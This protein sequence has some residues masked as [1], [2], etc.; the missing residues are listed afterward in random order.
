MAKPHFNPLV[1]EL[2]ATTPFVGPETLERQRGRRFRARLGA[3]ESAFGPSP[4]AIAAMQQAV[5][6]TW[7]YGDPESHDLKAEIAA[8]HGVA[9]KNVAIGAGIDGLLG[10]STRLFMQPGDT[11]V[12]SDGAYPTFNYFAAGQG[13]RL[14]KIPYT[15]DKEDLQALLD[16]AIRHGAR[17]I[18]VSNPDNPMG[19]WWSGTDLKALIDRL[20]GGLMLL[21]DEAYSD[22]AP[23]SAR[24]EVDTANPQVLRL[25]TFSKAYGMAGA[26]IGF[27]LGEPEM[28]AAFNK[29][30]AHFGVNRTGQIGALAAIRDQVYLDDVV[31]K[32]ARARERIA[33]IAHA[34]G[35]VPL[36]SATNFVAI[37]C[38]HTAEFAKSMV[39]EL[40][41]RDVF[42]RM[43]G[44]APLNR[45]IR[46][47]C[48]LDDALDVFAGA[49]PRALASAKA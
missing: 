23:A 38:L 10:L 14:I 42:V 30:R 19:S 22:T 29:I 36:E 9:V 20:P 31:R 27:A 49:L 18:Y 41:A 48:G 7:M 2:P 4:K 44:V 45:C 24:F 39:D 16:A 46:V 33:E 12:T 8:L 5:P 17:M 35:L 28:I 47:S 25:R 15:D 13:V 1:A 26:R 32:I 34:N 40:A 11:A 6:D 3:N 21:L 37:D 43:P